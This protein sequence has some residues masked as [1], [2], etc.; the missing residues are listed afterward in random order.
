MLGML[1][2][3]GNICGWPF[4]MKLLPLWYHCI[5][6]MTEAGTR[7]AEPVVILTAC[8]FSFVDGEHEMQPS[9]TCYNPAATVHGEHEMRPSGT[10]YYLNSHCRWKILL[11]LRNLNKKSNKN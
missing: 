10:C 3:G 1:G 9:G 2:G 8:L 5:K 7:T 11:I 6:K 4:M